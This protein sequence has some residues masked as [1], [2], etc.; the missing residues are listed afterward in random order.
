MAK[1][2]TS[3][4]ASESG[5]MIKNTGPA[6]SNTKLPSEVKIRHPSPADSS[7]GSASGNTQTASATRVGLKKSIE[8]KP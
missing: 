3:A 4:A 5:P 8:T 2:S 1:D 7:Q 6:G